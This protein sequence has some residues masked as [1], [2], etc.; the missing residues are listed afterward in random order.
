MLSNLSETAQ[1]KEIKK[2]GSQNLKTLTQKTKIWRNNHL[3]RRFGKY[4]FDLQMT[5]FNVHG[6]LDLL[7]KN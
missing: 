3:S 4:S 5:N 1:L 6:Q 2:A 7:M